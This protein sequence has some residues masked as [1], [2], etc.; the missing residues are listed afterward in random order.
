[1]R[2]RRVSCL[3]RGGRTRLLR[4]LIATAVL[5]LSLG[6]GAGLAVPTLRGATGFILVPT[7]QLTQ[8]A[9]IFTREG[10]VATSGTQAYS[11]VEGGVLNEDGRNFYNGKLQLLP[12]ITSDDEWI[13]GVAIGVRG[14]AG[15]NERRDY[16][17][18]VQKH[19]RF[20]DCTLVFGMNKTVSWKHG[21][22]KAFYGLEVPL[23]M[24]IS[25]LAD[26]EGQ[27]RKT[28]V[29][30]RWVLKKTFCFYD[31]LEDAR[32]QTANPKVNILGACYQKQF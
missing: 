21:D 27:T 13:P 28:N 20:P 18:V 11:A 32:G 4:S 30:V 8:A 16:Y 31:Y 3:A 25:V 12:D 9:S 15:T 6:A 26:H 29:G 14:V 19:F 10:K 17:A 23:F 5:A 2:L 24:G 1:M 7:A 22:W